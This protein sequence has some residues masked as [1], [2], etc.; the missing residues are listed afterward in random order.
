MRNACQGGV[1]I[2]RVEG[3]SFASFEKGKVGGLELSQPYICSFS[4][5]WPP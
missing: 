2:W 4:Q 1:M 3:E 5:T